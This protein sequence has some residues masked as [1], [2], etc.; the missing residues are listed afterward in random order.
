M[1]GLGLQRV[2][3]VAGLIFVVLFIAALILP[4]EVPGGAD[5]DQDVIS[6]YEDSGNR[7]KLMITGY[8]WTIAGIAFL[9]FVSGLRERLSLA[10]GG[11]APLSRL[12]FAGGVLM[13]AML[14]V[15]VAA[16]IAVPAGVAFQDEPVDAGVARFMIH[17][18]FAAFLL[19]GL[20][21]A[22]VMIVSTSLLAMRT[23]ALPTWV[24]WLGFV[25]AIVLLFGILFVTAIALM[26]WVLGVS[27]ALFMSRGSEVSNRRGA[28]ELAT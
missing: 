20:F 26:V 10:E 8:L 7:L 25:A 11:T 23:G 27:A 5:P 24:A 13:V 19:P 16:D 18:G 15:L 6:F 1:S 17:M 4:G 2:A 9:V 14:F 22:I 12:A 21:S 28:G 3:P